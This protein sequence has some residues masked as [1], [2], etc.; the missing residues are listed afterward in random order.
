MSG[1]G[2]K[3]DVIKSASEIETVAL[4]AFLMAAPTETHRVQCT[5]TGTHDID[6]GAIAAGGQNYPVLYYNLGANAASG[7]VTVTREHSGD[8]RVAGVAAA[9]GANAYLLPWDHDLVCMTQIRSNHRFFVTAT[10]N[11][12]AIV[13]AGGRMNPT[14]AHMNN[15]LSGVARNTRYEA[16]A[17]ALEA[18]GLDA[19]NRTMIVPGNGYVGGNCAVYGIQG[20]DGRWTFYSNDHGPGGGTTTQIWPG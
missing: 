5:V 15:G 7:V 10:L 19:A 6:R 20:G 13:I 8:L 17:Q 14:I 2:L 1:F 3:R 11:G 18:Q 9:I 16:M 12:C 4:P